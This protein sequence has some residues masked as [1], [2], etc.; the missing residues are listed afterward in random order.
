MTV[1]LSYDE[2]VTW[3]VSKL[4]HDGPSAYSCLAIM[5]DGDIGCL[6]EGGEVRYGEIVFEKFSLEWLTD[7]KDRL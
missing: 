3:P 2:G 6:Y 1:R 5:P 4:L 7:G